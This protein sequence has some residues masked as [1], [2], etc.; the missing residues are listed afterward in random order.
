MN[1]LHPQAGRNA[2]MRARVPRRVS[3]GLRALARGAKRPGHSTASTHYL[4]VVSTMGAGLRDYARSL[5]ERRDQV[6]I[7]RTCSQ[8]C[9]NEYL[10]VVSTICA[11]QRDYALS[12]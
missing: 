9:I 8:R 1:H 7:T 11:C 3:A 2:A 4:V 5:A 6:T 12:C 10:I